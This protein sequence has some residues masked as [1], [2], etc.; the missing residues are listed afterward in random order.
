MAIYLSM[1]TMAHDVF[2]FLSTASFAADG[3][4]TL[5]SLV[6][7]HFPCTGLLRLLLIHRQHS[8]Y[9]YDLWSVALCKGAQTQVC[10]EKMFV[11]K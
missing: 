10:N 7:L 6:C 3:N 1:W 5:C 8:Y 4:L 2:T 9:Y 11:R